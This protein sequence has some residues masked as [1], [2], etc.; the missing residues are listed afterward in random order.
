MK[1]KI[2]KPVTIA[3]HNKRVG[4]VLDVT[5]HLARSLKADGVAVDYTEEDKAKPETFS[6]PKAEEPSESSVDSELPQ[7]KKKN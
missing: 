4:D 2:I 6:E 1:I 5:I 7:K 3:R